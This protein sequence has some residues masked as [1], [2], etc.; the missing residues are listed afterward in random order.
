MSSLPL[1]LE[2]MY[3]IMLS[4]QAASLGIDT[5]IQ[6]F[7]LQLAT[8]SSRALRL[9]EVVSILDSAFPTS[10][11]PDAPKV[12]VRSACAPLLEILEDDTVS[13]IHH[14]FTEFLLNGGRATDQLNATTPQIPVLHSHEV[15]KRLSVL[16]ME[17]LRAGALRVHSDNVHSKA[18]KP[19]K[20]WGYFDEIPRETDGYN[21]Q[22]AKLQ[23]PFLD[24]AVANWAFHA[25]NYDCL[26]DD[27]FY[28]LEGFLD[29]D[30]IDFKKWLQLECMQTLTSFQIEAPSPL[31]VAAF[32]GLTAYAK[33]LLEAQAPVNPLDAEARTPLHWACARGHPEMVLLLLQKGATPDSE[34]IRGVKPIHEAARKNHAVI[35]KL[36]L[37]A[38]VDPL[39]PKTKENVKRP[40][41][42]GEVSTKGETAVEYAWLQ[43]HR[44]TIL[45]ML[46]FLRPEALEELFCQCCRYGKFEV[47]R[48]L[49]TAIEISPNATYSGATALYLACRAQNLEIVELLLSKGLMSIR[50]RSGR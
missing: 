42:C 11:I 50:L 10:L 29:P 36:L 21:F 14:S 2:E 25:S 47:V 40:L 33:R 20:R 27:F 49:L 7:L 41:L 12:V 9:N 17:Y 38:G 4:Q 16:C 13:I 24:Y 43:G 32:A 8:H 39:T 6:V 23:C 30:S 31:H 19:A 26:D 48:A 18:T 3:N 45:M 22:E 34:D 28:S 44:D 37:E 15:H 35:V 1:G 5:K 46:L